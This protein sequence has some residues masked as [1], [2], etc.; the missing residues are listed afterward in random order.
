MTGC[1][2]EQREH[3]MGPANA[4][5]GLAI[6]IGAILIG[7][8]TVGD[9]PT[10]STGIQLEIEGAGVSLSILPEIQAELKRIGV[11]VWPLQLDDVPEDIGRLLGQAS[12]TDVETARL[13]DHFLLSRERLLEIIVGG[14]R[15]GRHQRWPAAQPPYLQ[16]AGGCGCRVGGPEGSRLERELATIS[17]SIDAIVCANC[18]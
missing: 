14:G 6:L 17:S 3:R 12:L 4:R 10:T 13:R 18:E 15:A 11:G 7:S 8:C 5:F 1:L 9:M 2:W 16:H